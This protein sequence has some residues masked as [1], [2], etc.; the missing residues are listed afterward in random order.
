M[1]KSKRSTFKVVKV[2]TS[3]FSLVDGRFYPHPIPLTLEELPTV[4][5]FQEYYDHWFYVLG[6]NCERETIDDGSGL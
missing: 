4:E 2:T 5:E 6:D 1:T 3:G